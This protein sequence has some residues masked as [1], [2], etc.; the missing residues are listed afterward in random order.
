[1]NTSGTSRKSSTLRPRW[2]PEKS[3]VKMLGLTENL[4]T[5]EDICWQEQAIP[6]MIWN[7][8]GCEKSMIEVVLGWTCW[9]C[10]NEYHVDGMM[11]GNAEYQCPWQ[12]FFVIPLIIHV[13]AKHCWGCNLD[14]YCIM[15]YCKM[16]H[17]PKMLGILHV[18]P[19]LWS[20]FVDCPS[21]LW[22]G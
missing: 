18:T 15:T 3:E 10:L 20:F 1:M 16:I 17:P 8:L 7:H 2:T 6:W 19:N 13:A 11:E 9:G 4:G 21:F 5:V 12:F 22:L 14:V